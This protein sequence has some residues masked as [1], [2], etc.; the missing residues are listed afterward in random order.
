MAKK[1]MR[2][3]FVFGMLL[4]GI[5]VLVVMQPIDLQLPIWFSHGMAVYDV[6]VEDE[7]LYWEAVGR[8]Y[9]QPESASLADQA[10]WE[11][12]GLV[13][14]NRPCLKLLAEA[15]RIEP[16]QVELISQINEIPVSPCLEKTSDS[17]GAETQ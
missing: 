5:G 6:P 12:E 14:A 16:G 11:E 1:Q 17:S 9:A 4:M 7:W 3:I 10:R 15:G 8:T 13:H 2:R